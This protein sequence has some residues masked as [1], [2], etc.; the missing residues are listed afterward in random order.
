MKLAIIGAG[1]L[2]TLFGAYLAPY[3]DVTL[4]S[5]WSEQI[6]AI[7]SNGL[8]LLTPAGATRI[9]NLKI[10]ADI[11]ALAQSVDVALVLVKSYDSNYAARVAQQILKPSGIALTLQNGL[12][13]VEKLA[14]VL[15]KNRAVAGVTTQGATLTGVGGVRNTHTGMGDIQLADRTAIA[16]Q[17][18]MMNALFQKAGFLSQLT[19]NL[20]TV[21]WGKLVINVGINALTAIFG[22]TNHFLADEPSARKVLV[23]A[24]TEAV[25]V[26]KAQGIALP[27]AD[28]VTRVID[29]ARITGETRSSMLS[30]VTRRRRT[31]IDAINGAIVRAGEH[32]GIKMPV[33]ETLTQLVLAI[34]AGYRTT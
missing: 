18:A 26:A 4:V 23:A 28:P 33:N 13:N 15:G 32:L 12:G 25:S 10:N 5:R 16:S 7:R 29:V 11:T 17:M 8:K 20:D 3:A 6:D 1:A 9:I 24:V 2:G 14:A 34:E 30:D 21:L 22:K 27:Y 19:Q 31:E